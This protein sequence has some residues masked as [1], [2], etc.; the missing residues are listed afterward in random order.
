M[1]EKMLWGMRLMRLAS[2]CVEVIAAVMLLR[3]TDVRSM[4]RVNGLL[5][6]VGPMIFIGVSALGLAASL[7]KIQP[8]RLGL[9][10][11]GVVLV[12]WG[13]RS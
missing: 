2:A 6:L 5:G 1:E 8:A 3:M 9:I 4:I 10:L 7:G 12:L 11:L 13:A